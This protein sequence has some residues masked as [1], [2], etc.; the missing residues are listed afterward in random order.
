MDGVDT[1]VICREGC[2]RVAWPAAMPRIFIRHSLL[3]FALS[4]SLCVCLL[5]AKNL[6][7]TASSVDIR[8]L[9]AAFLSFAGLKPAHSTTPTSSRQSSRG[10][11]CRCHGMRPL[12]VSLFSYVLASSTCRLYC[13]RRNNNI[14]F[15]RMATTVKRKPGPPCSGI[16]W[17][18]L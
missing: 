1:V 14:L 6:F 2:M 17:Q 8:A 16:Q 10:C 9:H 5:D 13:R 12:R 4:L 18:S 15:V 7:V 11:R 3:S